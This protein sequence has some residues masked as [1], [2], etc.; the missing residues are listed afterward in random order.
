MSN[1]GL[2]TQ[3]LP[4]YDPNCYLCPTNTR[5]IGTVNPAYTDTFV[6]N[7]DYGA[8]HPNSSPVSETD[9]HDNLLKTEV[10]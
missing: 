7:N 6:F 3:A 8:L 10:L 2:D 4:Q 1:H 9:C 5:A